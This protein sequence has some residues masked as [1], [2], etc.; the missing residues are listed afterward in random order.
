[1]SHPQPARAEI[2]GKPFT[3]YYDY[4]QL[5]DGKLTGLTEDE[6]IEWF[7]LRMN[8]VFL[9]PLTHLHRGK[10]PAFRDL[11]SIK[12]HDL[13]ARSFVVPAFS[14]LLNGIEALGSFMTAK[15]RASKRAN[16]YAFITTSMR[17][18]CVRIPKSPY[19]PVN[20]L[21]GILWE[22]FRNG[23]AH[24]FCIEGGGIDN[25]ADTEPKGWK[26][27]NGRLQIGPHAFFNDFVLGISSFFREV[28]A[29]HRATFL[30][31]F[32]CVY[33]H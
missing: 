29:A 25:E 26:V 18:W 13:P 22:H 27:T 30:R 19:S 8:Y 11:N 10:T 2:N 16:F 1:M 14:V 31:R 28:E 7:R 6:K 33:P 5:R 23:I 3:L 4:D 32:R 12:Q 20:D 17:R 9:E 24:G 21:K 15:P